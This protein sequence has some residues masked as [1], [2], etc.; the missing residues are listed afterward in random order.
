MPV[1]P[2]VVIPF[3]VLSA[4]GFV[5]LE[6]DE[7]EEGKGRHTVQPPPSEQPTQRK[8]HDEHAG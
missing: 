3:L 4:R 8:T 2:G 5:G 6:D 1:L 7:G